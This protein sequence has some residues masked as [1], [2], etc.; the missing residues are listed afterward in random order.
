MKIL[1]STAGTVRDDEASAYFQGASGRGKCSPHA[2]E[3]V[4][5]DDIPAYITTKLNSR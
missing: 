2:S 3:N 4:K 1:D 5:D